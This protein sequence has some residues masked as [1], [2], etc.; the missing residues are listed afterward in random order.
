M[1]LPGSLMVGT[2]D[3]RNGDAGGLPSALSASGPP[4]DTPDPSVLRS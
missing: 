4:E 1:R 2:P 3:R